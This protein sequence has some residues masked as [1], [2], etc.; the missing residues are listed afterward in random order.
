MER[1]EGYFGLTSTTIRRYISYIRDGKLK[2]KKMGTR[3]YV[4]EEAISDF[5]RSPYIP[6]KKKEIQKKGNKNIRGEK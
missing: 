5:F 3:W 4:S 2:G 1:E 6:P